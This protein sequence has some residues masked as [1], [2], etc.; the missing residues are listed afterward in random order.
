VPFHQ[1]S[2]A[3]TKSLFNI[4]TPVTPAGGDYPSLQLVRKL[5]TV[6][7][8]TRLFEGEYNLIEI[9]AERVMEKYGDLLFE[10]EAAEPGDCVMF[11]GTTIHRSCNLERSTKPRFNIETRWSPV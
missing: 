8:Q 3:F 4:W 6:A 7:E 1:D 10:V 9:E 5:V 11:Y 2:T